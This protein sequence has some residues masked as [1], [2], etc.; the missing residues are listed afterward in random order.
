MSIT[1]GVG[2]MICAYAFALLALLSLPA[3]I[4]TGDITAIVDWV[5]QTFL[6]LVLLSII[7]FGQKVQSEKSDARLERTLKHISDD[8]NRIMQELKVLI[9][10]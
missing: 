3:I 9:K 1:N 7:L 4:N 8:N 2:T 6:Q 10:K 5:A